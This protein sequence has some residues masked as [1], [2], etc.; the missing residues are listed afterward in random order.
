LPRDPGPEAPYRAGSTVRG[1][2][3]VLDHRFGG[4]RLQLTAPVESVVQA[5]RPTAPV[6]AAGQLRIASFNVLNFFN[7]DG[8]GGGFPTE[9][10]AGSR[11]DL[12]RQRDKLVAAMVALDADVYA[13]MEIENDGFGGTSA[14]ADL[15]GALTGSLAADPSAAP[16]AGPRY[17]HVDAD[18]AAL[19]SDSIAVALI[20]RADR[21]RPV[22]DP[23]HLT[24]GTFDAD[25]RVPLAQAFTATTAG[26]DDAF[27]VV[28]NHF[29]SKGCRDAQGRNRNADDGQSCY[30]PVRAAS[31]TELA[32]WLQALPGNPGVEQALVLGDLNA[33]TREDAVRTRV[34]RG[35]AGLLSR[36]G[37]RNAPSLV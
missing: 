30:A 36:H 20:Y 14:V 3:G 21:V 25:S 17:V 19:G 33:H 24:G 12:R 26:D 34:N 2:E 18:L 15:A 4:W 35:L 13:L 7:G 27:L 28:V 6:H 37:R 10:G 11:N 31:A 8:K 32:D 1:I 29:K 9:R 22:G 5:P 16:D 23:R